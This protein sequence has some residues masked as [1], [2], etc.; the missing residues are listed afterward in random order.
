MRSG[1]RVRVKHQVSMP[2][3]QTKSFLRKNNA[4]TKVRGTLVQYVLGVSSRC[5]QRVSL[6][7]RGVLSKNQYTGLNWVYVWNDSWF[8][9]IVFHIG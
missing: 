1:N 9:R 8:F 5:L 4:P 6:P 3:F 2:K 7:E